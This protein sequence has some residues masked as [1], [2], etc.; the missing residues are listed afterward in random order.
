MI[1]TC[2]RNPPFQVY[3][4]FGTWVLEYPKQSTNTW[5]C[6]NDVWYNVWYNRTISPSS[7]YVYDEW[8]INSSLIIHKLLC[9]T[10]NCI[11]V[12]KRRKFYTFVCKEK[13]QQWNYSRKGP[14]KIHGQIGPDTRYFKLLK[15][16]PFPG[17]GFPYIYRS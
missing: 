8:F 1:P 16:Y 12:Q 3:V 2:K 15:V 4:L 6:G 9:N 13:L 7:C 14:F 17:P 11:Y 5:T 10:S